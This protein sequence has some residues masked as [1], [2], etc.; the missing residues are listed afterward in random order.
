MRDGSIEARSASTSSS[1]RPDAGSRPFVSE[2]A[3]AP[4]SSRIVDATDANARD[5]T[6]ST[7]RSAPAHWFGRSSGTG[8]TSASSGTSGR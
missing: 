5:G 8:V 7:T 6:A 3:I 1:R 4:S 2:S